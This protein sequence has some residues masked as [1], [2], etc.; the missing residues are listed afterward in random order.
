MTALKMGACDR[1]MLNALSLSPPPGEGDED[2]ARVGVV[3]GPGGA[4]PQR[5]LEALGHV[6]L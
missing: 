6:G 5:S 4:E 3:P 2:D 1:V